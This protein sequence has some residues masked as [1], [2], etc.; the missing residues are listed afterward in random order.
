VQLAE[1]T[2][3]IRGA[4]PAQAEVWADRGAGTGLF[5]LALAHLLGPGGQ[6]FAIDQNPSALRQLA[7]TITEHAGSGRA[8]A[9]R[10]MPV[11]ADFQKLLSLPA[12]FDVQLDGVLLANALHFVAESE[13]LLSELAEVIRPG[14]RSVVVEYDDRPASRW[15]PY[16]ISR[17]RLKRILPVP[18]FA[19]PVVV[20]SRPSRYGG[21]LYAAAALRREHSR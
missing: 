15:V 11:V 13:E 21:L 16:P 20:G 8:T 10:V 6:I 2:A 14:G 5:N 4:V 12:L 7:D 18:F 9:A 19:D 1:V 3:L 17:E